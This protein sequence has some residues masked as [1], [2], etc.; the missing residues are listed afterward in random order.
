M[1]T[2]T[3][4]AHY[5]ENILNSIKNVE[6]SVEALTQLHAISEEIARLEKYVRSSFETL[7]NHFQEYI[8]QINLLSS[9]IDFQRRMVH[10]KS[11]GEMA[12]SLFGYIREHVPCDHGFLCLSGKAAVGDR[13]KILPDAPEHLDLY[14]KFLET[15]DTE[16]NLVA[17]VE[18]KELGSL[19]GNVEQL[20]KQ[21][22]AWPVLQARAA[23]L[24]PLRIWG[25][26]V[27]LGVLVSHKRNLTLNHLSFVN[28][29][30]GI[31]SLLVFQHVYFFHLKER[32]LK[33]GQFA[34]VLED[35]KYSEYFEK[36]PLY[37][38]SVDQSG[39]ILH[40][41]AAALR[42]TPMEKEHIVGEKF[43]DLLPAD[44][45]KPFAEIL[46]RVEPDR[47]EQYQCPIVGQD[48]TL[49]IWQFFIT[50]TCLKEKFNLSVIF[51]VDVTA[52]YLREQQA[53]RNDVMGEITRFSRSITGYL[54]NLLNVMVPNVSLM[55]NQLPED[56]P[57]QKPLKTMEKS[58]GQAFG[59]VQKFLNYGLD[60]IEPPRK[61]NLNR[62]IGEIIRRLK[63]KFPEGIEFKVALDPAIPRLKL[64]P[65]RLT[66]LIKIFAQ[67]SLEALKQEG[68]IRIATR[69]VVVGEDEVLQPYLYHLPRGE[70]V[71]LAFEDN[72]PGIP[73]ESL[74][75][76]F[77]P[78][79]S[80][81]I[82]NEGMGLGL[83]IAYNIVRD[84]GGEIFVE[85]TPGQSTTF[86][87]YFPLERAELPRPSSENGQ[88]AA[89]K[90][91]QIL[92]IDDEYNIRTM[93][94]EIFEMRGYRVYT[95]ANGKEGVEIFHRHPE[96]IDLVILDM[97]MPV[98]DG[99]AAFKEIMKQ[100]QDQKVIVI[101]GFTRREDLQEILNNGGVAYLSKPFNVSDI[102]QQVEEALS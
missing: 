30:S 29:N 13:Q 69:R 45:R 76:I 72:G 14:R 67:N 81:R 12:G 46:S 74:K 15:G 56:H 55:Q 28:L 35:L 7:D 80:T 77:K 101:S 11:A 32:L 42:H 89:G 94:K 20:Q 83:F 2:T 10:F 44:H 66:R 37:I 79:F 9:L 73:P 92:V 65:K 61:V 22:I 87:V 47:L 31:I 19:F 100:K 36:S 16:A 86:R 18:E 33:Q 50:R 68:Y 52:R 58:L 23:I 51:A 25:R 24:F 62:L 34:K 8:Q 75:D 84:M 17:L 59:V 57:L 102:I 41:N 60:E 78:F 43:L 4:I 49:H 93:L 27:G 1:S 82:K 96:E 6:Q 97:V 40:A 21:T 99:K 64:F 71:E 63:E 98:M 48:K 95:A 70:Y 53:V 91:R 85:S 3:N 5:F 26:F 90:P 38:Y 39:V 54:N 88:T